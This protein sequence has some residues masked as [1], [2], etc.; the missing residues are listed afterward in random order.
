MCIFDLGVNCPFKATFQWSTALSP[1][2][3]LV[4]RWRA[5]RTAVDSTGPDC[6]NRSRIA[7]IFCFWDSV[8][9]TSPRAG[10]FSRHIWSSWDRKD[11]KPT[12]YRSSSI[13]SPHYNCVNMTCLYLLTTFWSALTAPLSFITS[14][15]CWSREDL[16]VAGRAESS[17]KWWLSDSSSEIQNGDTLSSTFKD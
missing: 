12:C 2:M 3:A 4:T 7:W 8:V 11:R 14:V 15:T 13:L 10:L 5:V 16:V 9:V 17:W 6:S 1:S